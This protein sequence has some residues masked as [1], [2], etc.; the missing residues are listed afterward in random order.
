MLSS[1]NPPPSSLRVAGRGRK[2]KLD[3]EHIRTC[4]HVV[5]KCVYVGTEW[6]PSNVSNCVKR[7][8]CRPP[9]QY[10]NAKFNAVWRQHGLFCLY[11]YRNPACLDVA[12]HAKQAETAEETTVVGT[13]GRIKLL[14]PAHCPTAMEVTL[15]M[16]GRGV[17]V[18]GSTPILAFE[19]RA[20]SCVD[21]VTG[22]FQETFRS[23]CAR[24][25]V[26]VSLPSH[27]RFVT[28]QLVFFFFL[29]HL[30][31]LHLIIGTLTTLHVEASLHLELCA[32]EGLQ[33][34]CMCS[35]HSLSHIRV[36]VTDSAPQVVCLLSSF[37]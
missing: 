4:L 15:K 26:C 31:S 11:Y 7:E 1:T 14:A 29:V 12:L 27:G 28:R 35:G 10:F 32:A 37:R 16:N 2:A 5:Y 19:K 33:V 13:K 6:F 17:C 21:A 34:G 30:S 8:D 36:S 18:S 24:V 25:T 3:E 20:V 22:M 9:R 23:S